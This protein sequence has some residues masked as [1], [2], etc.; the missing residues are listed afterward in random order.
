LSTIPSLSPCALIPPEPRSVR[1]RGRVSGTLLLGAFVAAAIGGGLTAL[2]VAAADSPGLGAPLRKQ[3]AG[4]SAVRWR[5][6]GVT[7]TVD[8]SAAARSPDISGAACAAVAAWKV[9]GAAIPDVTVNGASGRPRPAIDGRNTLLQVDDPALFKK[10]ALAVT[11]L[12][13][14]NATG[15]VVD[16]DIALNAAAQNLEALDGDSVVGAPEQYDL[17]SVLTHELGHFL[18]LGEDYEDNGATMYAY[19]Q[20]GTLAK[21]VLS[22]PDSTA[23][24]SL[25]PETGDAEGAS[26]GCAWVGAPGGAGAGALGLLVVGALLASRRRRGL[27]AAILPVGLIAVGFT[28]SRPGAASGD[29][30]ASAAVEETRSEWSDGVLFT[31]VVV[32][33]ED[34]RRETLRVAGGSADGLTQVVGGA[35]VPAAGARVAVRRDGHGGLALLPAVSRGR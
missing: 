7:L 26:E 2:R 3:T 27:C 5:A 24:R 4:G 17:Q 13:F 18:G 19:V 11:L 28:V 21:R 33:L 16:A 8:S 25:Y 22:E 10:G 1:S 34:G 30:V 23:I 31:D 32:R 15:A 35:L 14:D 20:P 12:T 29:T 9:A 6:K